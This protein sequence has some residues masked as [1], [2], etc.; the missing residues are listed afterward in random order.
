MKKI[1]FITL[2]YDDA[3]VSGNTLFHHDGRLRCCFHHE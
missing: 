3:A 1:Q 2:F